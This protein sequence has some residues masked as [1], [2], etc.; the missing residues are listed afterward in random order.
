MEKDCSVYL[1][2]K[3]V[4]VLV[5]SATDILLGGHLLFQG[6]PYYA[7]SIFCCLFLALMASML[8]V[9]FGRCRQGDEMSLSKYILISGKVT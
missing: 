6:Y 9:C 5:D 1:G 4:L 2:L 8:Y 3:L 7:L